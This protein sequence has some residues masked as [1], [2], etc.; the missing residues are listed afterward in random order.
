MQ[1]VFLI[2]AV[3]VVCFLIPK[4]RADLVALGSLLALYLAGILDVNEALSGFSNSAV[5]MITALFIIG[6]GVFRTGLAQRAGDIL[7]KFSGKSEFKM[8]VI[9]MLLVAGLSGF[10]SNT[11]TVAILIPV[12]VSLCRRLNLA[13]SKFLMP[14]AFA[15]SMGGTLTLI[16]TPPNLLANQSMVDH[17]LNE[18][19]FFAFAPIGLLALIVG[20]TYL[21]F[22]AR[23]M[24]DG[25]EDKF[26]NKKDSFDGDRLLK[27]YDIKGHIH[28][29]IVPKNKR[30]S[31]KTLKG[32]DW[33]SKYGIV[34]LEVFKKT[35]KNRIINKKKYVYQ[36]RVVTASYR[37][38][39]GDILVIYS[40]TNE[41][42]D[43]KSLG[44]KT[45]SSDLRDDLKLDKSI[46][47]E[48][49]LA[50]QSNL[51][52][53]SL[54]DLDFRKKIGLTILS[55]KKR[56]KKAKCPDPNYKL[57]DGDTLLVHGKW[58]VINNLAEEK[59]NTI[60]LNYSHT[61]FER[62]NNPNKLKLA[63]L[64]LLS[65][66]ALMV[67]E[68]FPTVIV[69]LLA[70]FAMV[71]SGCTG[72]IEKAYEAINWYTII[73]IACMLPMA[74]ALEKT[75]GVSYISETLTS[76]LGQIGPL[77]TLAGLYVITAVFGFFMSNTA[78]A[79]LLYPIAVLTAE[80]L[81]VNPVPMVMAVAYSSSMSFTTPFSTPPNMLAMA[82]GKYSFWDYVK[83]GLPLQIV[84]GIVII[85]I[86]PI[87]Y[88][89]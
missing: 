85:L 44:L 19:S 64:I 26:Q 28:Y 69:I 5:V 36:R 34:V 43:F 13:P 15:S 31:G 77:S 20:I 22:V 73:L 74:D 48:I 50:P 2:L 24:L 8:T 59:N 72:K 61:P 58:D 9:M 63:I 33:S 67:L 84:I 6:E 10:M 70:A 55:V 52:D 17:G 16:G 42:T 30:I 38:E 21:W 57:S 62:K 89:F 66:V 81:G 7:V 40:K 35:Y 45:C 76:T 23:K 11:G 80:Q 88:S 56:L 53:R 86:L 39:A 1:V 25:K 49:I 78:T 32:L 82:A 79:V 87:F 54:L 75:G 68:V 3:T 29:L 51:I 18:F 14:L 4:F 60:V 65:M 47:A 83:V 41:I 12:V 27:E 71:I 37:L 46:F